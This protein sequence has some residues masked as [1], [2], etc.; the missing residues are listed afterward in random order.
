MASDGCQLKYDDTV[1]VEYLL[2]L[3]NKLFQTQGIWTFAVI[4]PTTTSNSNIQGGSADY[5]PNVV[6]CLNPAIDEQ[7]A[8]KHGYGLG[9]YYRGVTPSEKFIGWSGKDGKKDA[10]TLLEEILMVK[11]NRPF[12]NCTWY[13]LDS[14]D[15]NNTFAPNISF[16]LLIHPYGR[17]LQVNVPNLAFEKRHSY[18]FFETDEKGVLQNVT[19]LHFF[20]VDPVNSPLIYPASFQMSGDQMNINDFKDNGGFWW[21]TT[22]ISNIQHEDCDPKFDCKQYNKI[23][24]YGKCL[25]KE[26]ARLFDESW[27]APNLS[28]GKTQG[29][30]ATR[31]SI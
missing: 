17:C 18:A 8:E 5:I 30:C 10:A 7:V 29:T 27:T 15:F 6:V 1:E 31:S 4:K 16:P 23:N 11:K 3:L 25:K 22:K 19:A 20:F 2:M 28:W 26:L 21:F 13:D 24:T 12:V 9:H 14:L